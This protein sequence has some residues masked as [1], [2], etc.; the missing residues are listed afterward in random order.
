MGGFWYPWGSWNQF[1]CSHQGTLY[2]NQ[3]EKFAT[4]VR[5]CWVRLKMKESGPI[6]RF[7]YQIV[8]LQLQT[9]HLNALA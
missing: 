4:T 9:S 7:K 2:T 1:P 5:I 3:Q 6:M 8:T